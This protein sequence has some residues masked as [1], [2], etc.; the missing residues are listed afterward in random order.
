MV[1][2][3]HFS[4]SEAHCQSSNPY[5]RRQTA[6]HATRRQILERINQSASGDRSRD[7]RRQ[8]SSQRE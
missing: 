1:E 6:T 8:R 5:E 4:Y 2:V 3:K 7:Q